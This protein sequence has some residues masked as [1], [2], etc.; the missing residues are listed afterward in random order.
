[1]SNRLP[2]VFDQ[3]GREVE[4]HQNISNVNLP[5]EIGRSNVFTGWIADWQNKLRNRDLQAFAESMRTLVAIADL[6]VQIDILTNEANV[7]NR[8]KIA[9]LEL[10]DRLLQLQ[11]SVAE[12]RELEEIERLKREKQKL[13]LKYELESGQ[14]ELIERSKA[15]YQRFR[16]ATQYFRQMLADLDADATIH[17]EDKPM[18]R[19]HIE[20]MREKHLADISGVS[21]PQKSAPRRSMQEK[22]S[23]V[24]RR[25]ARYQAEKNYILG[26]PG[27]SEAEKRAQ[28]ISLSAECEEDCRRIMEG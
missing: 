10:E 3:N 11:Q 13:L 7:A 1:M 23:E 28:I 12:R 18:M 24:A 5:K 21:I 9:A 19:A 27:L 22:Q 14:N 17:Y 25:Q 15:P 6:K 8:K 16:E 2:M 4:S 20:A 26:D